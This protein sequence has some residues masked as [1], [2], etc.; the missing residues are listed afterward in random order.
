MK[1][2]P[3]TPDSIEAYILRQASRAIGLTRSE[4]HNRYSSGDGSRQ[5]AYE[6]ADAM[7]RDGRLHERTYRMGRW[8][9]A[10]PA[11]AAA[12]SPNVEIRQAPKTP[13]LR[14]IDDLNIDRRGLRRVKV[15]V[16]LPG[17]R[18]DAPQLLNRE[19]ETPQPARVVEVQRGPSYTHD[20]RYQVGPGEKV[21]ALF[22]GLGIGR[23]LDERE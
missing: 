12:W 7:V 14:D 17:S 8:M 2:I 10:D 21:P 4:I 6:I 22:S 5:T 20:P 11:H 23:Y 3:P 13:V 19:P 16:H 1:R 9:F 15:Q 18:V